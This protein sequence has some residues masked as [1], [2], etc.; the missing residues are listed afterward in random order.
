MVGR[1]FNRAFLPP[2]FFLALG[3][4][5]SFYL[6]GTFTLS[7]NPARANPRAIGAIVY[8][9]LA[10]AGAG[11]SFFDG[12]FPAIAFPDHVRILKLVVFVSTA[13][14][15][16]LVL[17]SMKADDAGFIP[18]WGV[19]GSEVR[20]ILGRLTEDP[21]AL[22]GDSRLLKLELLESESAS[23]VRVSASGRSAV[24]FTTKET[25]AAG[26]MLLL[27]GNVQV[28]LADEVFRAREASIIRKAST[29]MLLRHRIRLA[30]INRLETRNW[31]G[32][33]AALLLGTKDGLESGESEL[34][35]KAGCA[36]VLAL[37]G[38]HLAVISALI[39]LILKRIL[40]LRKSAIMGVVMVA[41]YVYLAGS[42]ASLVRAGLMYAIAA[43]AVLGGFPRRVLLILAFAFLIQLTLDPQAA[44]S[45]SFILSY[46]A[47]AGIAVLSPAVDDLLRGILPGIIRSP[48]S[49]SIGAF[50]ATAAVSAAFFGVLRPIGLLAGMILAPA[51]TVVMVGGLAWLVL[52]TLWTPLGF[53]VDKGLE[54]VSFLTHELVTISARVP[55]MPI[56]SA[57]LVTWVSLAA[58]ALLLYLQSYR[59]MTRN[60]LEPFA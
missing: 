31:G 20:R 24:F 17:G 21:R 6:A 40:G 50:L 52:D 60:R 10:L 47:L 5:F 18:H 37:S 4:A 36:H 27:K 56:G 1:S 29:L 9:A 54:L 48:I 49:A 58:C 7:N 26:D 2:L 33:A 38:M 34:Y 14:C 12:F 51:A 11:I 45:L 22:A 35:V 55:G 57:I 16:G 41:A 23:G 13:F 19:R 44:R 30:I 3:A 53:I 28:G 42:Q 25:Y 59:N 32:L 46:L 8:M 39:S 15:G 43:C